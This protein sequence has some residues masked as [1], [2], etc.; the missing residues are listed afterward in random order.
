MWYK[1]DFDIKCGDF[2]ICTYDMIFYDMDECD[3]M[4]MLFMWY[5]DDAFVAL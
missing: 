3:M 1:T 2:F 4:F 5:D